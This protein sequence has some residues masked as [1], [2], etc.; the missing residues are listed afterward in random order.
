MLITC[1]SVSL[2]FKLQNCTI[3]VHAIFSFDCSLNGKISKYLS[4]WLIKWIVLSWAIYRLYTSLNHKW[5]D[6]QSDHF[7]TFLEKP[8]A[9]NT[10]NTSKAGLDVTLWCFSL[11]EGRCNT[12]YPRQNAFGSAQATG[13]IKDYWEWNP[14]IVHKWKWVLQS[15]L[16]NRVKVP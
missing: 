1:T 11:Q 4:G 15:R 7:P 16:K 6:N 12:S 2:A 9:S 3:H 14:G 10:I 13:T 5:S 8:Q